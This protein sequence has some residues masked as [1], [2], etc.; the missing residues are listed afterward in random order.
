MRRTGVNSA[1]AVAEFGGIR[2]MLACG[3][4]LKASRPAALQLDL[5]ARTIRR[6][7]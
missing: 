7:G 3:F 4:E 5:T 2:F 6:R 1:H